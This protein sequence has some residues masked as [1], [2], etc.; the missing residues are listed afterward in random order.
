MS[1]EDS[2]PFSREF[3]RNFSTQ[4]FESMH[5]LYGGRT[6][7]E[8]YEGDEKTHK[9]T[10]AMNL[11]VNQAHRYFAIMHKRVTEE[12]PDYFEEKGVNPNQFHQDFIREV[13]FE[14]MAKGQAASRSRQ[15]EIAANGYLND[16][17]RR[18]VNGGDKFHPYM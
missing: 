9:F 3:P 18:L 5:K 15:A 4:R 11:C 12:Q 14:E 6:M 17:I 1:S 16:Q 8:Q 7:K 10:Q 13:C 2:K